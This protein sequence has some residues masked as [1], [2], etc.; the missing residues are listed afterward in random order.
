MNYA[1]NFKTSEST[2]VLNL[3]FD[4]SSVTLVNKADNFYE[5]ISVHALCKE[6]RA[7]MNNEC[8]KI[9]SNNSRIGFT[10]HAL[11][12]NA[13]SYSFFSALNISIDCDILVKIIATSGPPIFVS[14]NPVNLNR[15]SSFGSNTRDFKF[16]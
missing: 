9:A 3:V 8:H 10:I 2:S 13:A 5:G 14:A 16:C 1:F 11:I 4:T 7:A 15:Q 12:F 6:I